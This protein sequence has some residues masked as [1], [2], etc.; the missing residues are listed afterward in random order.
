MQPVDNYHT[1]SHPLTSP[2]DSPCSPCSRLHL[3]Q[4]VLLQALAAAQASAQA[5]AQ[6]QQAHDLLWDTTPSPASDGLLS[7]G[8]TASDGLL[9]TSPEEMVGEWTMAAGGHNTLVLS[10]ASTQ[11]PVL[12]GAAAQLVPRRVPAP[13]GQQQ[14]LLMTTPQ[15]AAAQ[16]PQLMQLQAAPEPQGSASVGGQSLMYVPAHYVMLVPQQQEQLQA[17]QVRVVHGGPR[18]AGMHACRQACMQ[19]AGAGSSPPSRVFVGNLHAQATEVTLNR[20]FAACGRVLC[21]KVGAAL[22]LLAFDQCLTPD[23]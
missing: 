19:A 20:L 15:P 8:S 13:T 9:S 1:T 21:S 16:Q 4:S 10:S 6:E 7:L 12:H 11:W 5:S 17:Q 18:A 23:A 14:V 3:P 2:P 22:L